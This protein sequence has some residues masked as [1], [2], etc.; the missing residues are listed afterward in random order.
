MIHYLILAHK[1]PKQLQILIDSLSFSE[2]RAYIHVDAKAWI[3]EIMNLKGAMYVTKRTSIEWGGF[4]M[5]QATLDAFSEILPFMQ[6]W[7]HLVIMSWQ[8]F[9]IKS[10]SYITSFLNQHKWKSFIEYRIQPNNEWNILNRVI[11]YHFHDLHIPEWI[12]KFIKKMISPLYPVQ[13]IR[14]QAFCYIWQRIVNFLLPAKTYLVHNYKIYWGSSWQIISMWH[15]EYIL[16]FLETQKGRRF[17]K[18]F[19]TVAGPD[20]L[21]FQTILLNSSCQDSIINNL[22]WYIDWKKWPW[23]PRI[24]DQTDI[25]MIK[26]SWKLFA[27][28]FDLEENNFTS[29]IL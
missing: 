4:S 13:S 11:R 6:A 27:R 14:N 7:D 10:P 5:V 21:F 26:D 25:S 12:D 24:L 28:K 2:S 3:W 19:L 20:E 23:L 22:Q 9:P 16:N 18:E 29:L 1:S 15:V 17:R 8:D